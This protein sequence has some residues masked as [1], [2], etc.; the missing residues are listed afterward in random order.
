MQLGLIGLGKMGA[1]MARRLCRKG[2]EVVGYDRDAATV[3]PAK[4]SARK[5]CL[6]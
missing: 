6:V 5:V 3:S 2:I 4:R 1:N